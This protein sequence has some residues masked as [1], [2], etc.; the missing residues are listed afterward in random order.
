MTTRQ[1]RTGLS[2]WHTKIAQLKRDRLRGIVRHLSSTLLILACCEYSCQYRKDLCWMVGLRLPRQDYNV[3]VWCLA[4]NDTCSPLHPL[5][6]PPT[7]N[8]I[9]RP[10]PYQFWFTSLLYWSR[11]ATNNLSDQGLQFV[12]FFVKEDRE[13]GQRMA[14]NHGL[15]WFPET[16]TGRTTA[17]TN[18]MDFFVGAKGG[19]GKRAGE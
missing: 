15:P 5:R 12:S 19:N 4:E 16:R 3:R 17:Q 10:G 8:Q 1:A 13:R 9:A 6:P 2:F 7:E 18:K 14:E 11:T